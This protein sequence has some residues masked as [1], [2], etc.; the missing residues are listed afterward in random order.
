[1]ILREVLNLS[2]KMSEYRLSMYELAKNK[3]FTNP[4]VI[5]MSQQLDVEIVKVQK[6]LSKLCRS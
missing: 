3:D 5:K 6:I 4:Y 1:M 2:N